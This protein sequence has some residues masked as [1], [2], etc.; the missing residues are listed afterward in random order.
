MENYD[1]A[2]EQLR[3]HGLVVEK[4]DTTG[5]I[6]RVDCED[7][8][9]KKHGWYVA[10]LFRTAEGREFIVGAFGD[11]RDSDKGRNIEIGST[12][13]LSEQERAELKHQRELQRR[14]TEAERRLVAD[15]A[16]ARARR[17]WSKLPDS[18]TSDYLRRK[19][20]RAY[21]L[22]FSRGSVVVP[23]HDE[24]GELVGLQFIDGE[25]SKKFLTGTAKRGA[26]HW[27]GDPGERGTLAIA[28]GYATAATVHEATGW[29][30]AVAFDAGNL[31]PV[32]VA[33]RRRFPGRLLVLCADN[34]HATA[35]NPGVSKATQACERVAG[36][37]AVPQF[38]MADGRTDWNDLQAE[39]GVEAVRAQLRGAV[40][41]HEASRQAVSSVTFDLEL[42]LREFIVI[43]GTTFVWDGRRGR[44][45]PLASLRVS[46]GE[47]LVKQWLAHP[48]RR[49]VDEEAVVFDPGDLDPRVP[50]INLFTGME[51]TPDPSGHC[52]LLLQHLFK[53][54]GERER[55]Y[56]WVLKWIA[57]PLQRLGTK[58]QTAIVMYGAEGTGKNLFW[59]AVLEIYGRWGVLVGQAELESTFNGWESAKLFMVADEVVPRN[60]MR[61]MK[62]RL[63]QLI[64]S[65]RVMVNEKNMPLREERNCMNGVF[66]SNENQPLLLDR[67]DR[68]YCGI[69]CDAVETA[70]YFRAIGAELRAGGSEAFYHYLLN[71]D[72]E[73][74]DEHTKPFET[75]ERR[76][77]I[78]AA[79]P[80]PLRFWE[81][82][83]EQLLPLPYCCCRA[84]D[85]FLAFRAWCSQTGERFVP[86]ETAFGLA[87]RSQEGTWFRKERP[88]IVVG[89]DK[90]TRPI[91][92][93]LVGDDIAGGA[94]LPVQTQVTKFRDSAEEYLKEQRSVK[95]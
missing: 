57:L 95:L 79:S 87:L 2:L 78:D 73:D 33:V 34:D 15:E 6:V 89:E 48:M 91:C 3:A 84:Q 11:W 22:R 46:A 54:C 61:H 52:T 90:S 20:V 41:A 13:G 55:L 18:G 75:D 40:D 82:W 59:R 16:A 26:W 32:A 25:G 72:L 64:T 83:R 38:G 31:M 67:G 17:I 93:M 37:L 53:L 47:A 62:G 21:G 68:R 7:R 63:K 65:D 5:R 43:H 56:D 8:P 10:H 42:L 36:V 12:R 86:N 92:Y 94:E 74:F 1:S 50:K 14:A 66:L 76:E 88:R 51:L 44:L 80:A 4:I 60:E 30:V 24:R 27:V 9:G 45:M 58:M 77:L 39:Q 29:P 69:R 19:G 49:M 28:E 70:D 35:G 23:L 71:Y 81:E 85:L